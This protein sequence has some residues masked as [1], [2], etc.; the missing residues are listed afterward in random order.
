MEGKVREGT[1]AR[2]GGGLRSITFGKD[3]ISS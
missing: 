2:G 1:T 3:L